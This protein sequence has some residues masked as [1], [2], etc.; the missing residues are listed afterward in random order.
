MGYNADIRI[1]PPLVITQE[2]AEEGISMMEEVFTNV[3]DRINV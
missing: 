1:N 3:A 2:V